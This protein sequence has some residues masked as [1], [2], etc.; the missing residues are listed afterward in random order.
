[1]RSLRELVDIDDPAWPLLEGWFAAS[2]RTVEVLPPS[3]ERALLEL[4][5]TTR[6]VL[7][8]LAFE[9]GGLAV[10]HG[11]LRILGGGHGELPSLA[12]GAGH[13]TVAYDVLGGGF[14]ING[15]SL[16]DVV[17]GHVGYFGPDTLGWLD[18]G[19]GH[20][21]FVEWALVGDLPEFY[22]D[23]RWAGWETEVAHLALGQG[24]SVFPPLWSAEALED[25]AGTSRR[26]VPFAEILAFRDEMARPTRQG[27][28]QGQSAP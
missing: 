6:S 14:A 26:A 28:R 10:D 11:W 21:G 3:G 15:G 22:S 9:S 16:P 1:M 24:L 20:G 17:V 27:R 25:M 19:M 13:V 18:T 7:G 12:P 4:Q 2:P 23:L 5:V 8:A